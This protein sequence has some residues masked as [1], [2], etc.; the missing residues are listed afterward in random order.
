MIGLLYPRLAQGGGRELSLK[1]CPRDQ[2]EKEVHIYSFLH[3]LLCADPTIES[4]SV[5][6]K[7]VHYQSV[8]CIEPGDSYLSPSQST[9]RDP[10]AVL[11][12][13]AILTGFTQ[14]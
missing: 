7:L 5:S 13:D 10:L 6:R 11:L 9:L 14:D 8:V 12:N 2:L 4:H 3:R 1:E